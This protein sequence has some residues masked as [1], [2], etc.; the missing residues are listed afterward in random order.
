MQTPA[1]DAV[2]A[3]SSVPFTIDR[4]LCR[5]ADPSGSVRITELGKL[6]G[7]SIRVVISAAQKINLCVCGIAAMT[8][9]RCART[10]L[11][12]RDVELRT[13]GVRYEV[14]P[15]SKLAV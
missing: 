5:K 2:P 14:V 11:T 9:Y 15:V 13:L 12:E 6:S 10:A 3:K 4:S 7:I 8:L 1:T